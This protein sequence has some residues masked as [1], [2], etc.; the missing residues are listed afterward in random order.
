MTFRIIGSRVAAE[1]DF[2]TAEMLE[3]E[4]ASGETFERL[5]IRHPGASAIV[6]ATDNEIVLLRQYRPPVGEWMLEIPAGKLDPG[7]D[8]EATAVREAAE[9]TGFRPSRVT[10][11][12]S[13][14]TGPGFTDEVVHLFL[15]RD[16]VEAEA[17]P[18][19]PEERAAEIV[20]L[21]FSEA[22]DL[23]DR[24]SITDAKSVAGLLLAKEVLR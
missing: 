15:G 10:R 7:E 14:H 13:I 19:G 1:L 17:R 4:S 21:P 24:G 6:L 18:D 8:P 23:I 2:V 22:F 5:V 11:L 16:L 9:E 12:A 3:V 20:T